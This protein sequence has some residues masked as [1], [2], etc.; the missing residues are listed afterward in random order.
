MVQHKTYLLLAFSHSQLRIMLPFFFLKYYLFIL[1]LVVLSVHCCLGF[2]SS[3]RP[4]GATVQLWYTGSSLQ[5]LLLLQ[6]TSSRACW[7][8]QLQHMD[9]VIVTPRL[10]STGTKVVTHGFS[11]SVACGIFLDQGSNLCL[12]HWQEDSLPLSHQ[13]SPQG[14]QKLLKTR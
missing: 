2:F 6:I 12:L 14:D 9:S 10:Q 7:L 11:C 5:W 4:V 1:F 3:C 8:Q 13:G